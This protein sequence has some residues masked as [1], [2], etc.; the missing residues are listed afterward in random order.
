MSIVSYQ[1][2]KKYEKLTNKTSLHK[3]SSLF[4][5]NISEAD[6]AK[7]NKIWQAMS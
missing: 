1:L 6:N 4:I 2:R 3:G 7:F 5:S